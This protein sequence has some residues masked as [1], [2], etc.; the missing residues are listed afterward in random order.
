MESTTPKAIEAALLAEHGE[1]MT[2][3]CLRRAMGY[4]SER[5]YQRAIKARTVPVSVV[6]LPGRRGWFART[7]DVAA[8]LSDVGRSG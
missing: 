6:C 5:T 4:R 1:L 3:E 8:W 2:G 7:R